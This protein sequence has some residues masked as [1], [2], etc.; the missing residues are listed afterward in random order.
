[1][2]DQGVLGNTEAEEAVIGIL[3]NDPDQFTSASE[4]L[5]PEDFSDE[6]CRA[7]YSAMKQLFN[8]GKVLERVLVAGLMDGRPGGV[9]PGVYLARMAA[10]APKQGNV[11][12]FAAPVVDA[13]L[14]RNGRKVFM[15]AHEVLASRT[16]VFE[17]LEGVHTQVIDLMSGRGDR[18]SLVEIIAGQLMGRALKQ[19]PETE[20]SRKAQLRTGFNELDDLIGAMMPEDLIVCGGATSMGKTAIAQQIAMM[21]AK[22]GIPVLYESLEMSSEQITARFLSQESRISVE[23]IEAGN[24]VRWDDKNRL[25]EAAANLRGIPLFI[26]SMARG[27]VAKLLSRV[28]HFKKKHDIGLVIVDHLHYIEGDKRTRDTFDLITQV[29]KGLKAAAKQTKIPWLCLSHLNRDIMKR[30]NKRPQMS[31]LFGASEIEKSADTIFFVHRPIYW[32]EQQEPDDRDRAQWEIEKEKWA[33]RAELVLAKRRRGK[34]KG[35]RLC[36][37]NERLTMFGSIRDEAADQPAQQGSFL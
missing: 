30:E 27:T 21:V 37:F 26:E 10:T 1:M 28:M 2:S 5:E 8:E 11:T 18:G 25:A 34:G 24:V 12:D 20:Q 7:A 3:M 15:E 22:Q 17:T 35:V 13:A 29:V 31:D 16:D 36:A 6:A 32:L 9:S 19:T 4:M 23:D 33:G 14:R